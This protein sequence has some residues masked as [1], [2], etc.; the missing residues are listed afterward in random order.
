MTKGKTWTKQ[1]LQNLSKRLRI[2]ERQSRLLTDIILGW[3]QLAAMPRQTPLALEF[4]DQ[5]E[6]H[7]PSHTVLNFF[8]PVWTFLARHSHDT[9]RQEMITFVTITETT[10]G[11][12]RKVPLPVSGHD[13]MVAIPGIRGPEIGSLVEKLKRAYYNG[14]WRTRHEGLD[15]IRQLH[16]S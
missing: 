16:F 9:N 3:Q 13:V 7:D 12:R 15:F 10:F 1:T 4:V 8:A 5:M 2:S 6:H 11:D 14:E